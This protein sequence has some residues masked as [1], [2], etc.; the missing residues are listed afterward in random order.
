MC[1]EK[2]FAQES[3]TPDSPTSTPT[4]TSSVKRLFK[5][6][7]QTPILD[8]MDI[9]QCIDFAA[10]EGFE[11]LEVAAWK[12]LPP[13]Q[14]PSRR[15]ADVATLRVLDVLDEKTGPAEVEKIL[16]YSE[17]KGVELASSLFCGNPLA[18]PADAEW[19]LKVIQA[20]AKLKI[21]VL[22]CFTGRVKEMNLEDS[23][24]LL[25]KVFKPIVAEAERHNVKLAIEHCPMLFSAAE[26]PYGCNLMSTPA[27]WERAFELIPS[28]YFGICINISHFCWLGINL[29]E[30]IYN[31]APKILAAHAKDIKVH[32]RKLERVGILAPPLDYMEPILPGLGGDVPWADYFDALYRIK[33]QGSVCLEFEDKRFEPKKGEDDEITRRAILKAKRFLDQF[34]V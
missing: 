16:A 27:I 12:P 30:P 13:G 2:T 23:F 34:V 19:M 3:Q 25:E 28:D 24:Q 15:Y 4:E 32:C 20:S 21:P 9:F 14:K 6:G 11:S 29:I 7:L 17:E 22:T 18:N 8:K 31:F 33:F 5:L 10:Q 1:K 26:M